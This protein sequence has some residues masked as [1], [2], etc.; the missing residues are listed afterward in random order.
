[1]LSKVQLSLKTYILIFVLITVY[2]LPT[3]LSSQAFL[4][5]AS[6]VNLAPLDPSIT[7]LELF[8]L[9]GKIHKR[10]E[11]KRPAFS[12]VVKTILL[13]LEVVC[14]KFWMEHCSL[15]MFEVRRLDFKLILKKKNYNN[16]NFSKQRTVK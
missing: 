10:W 4:I 7:H 14:I 6:I 1:M 8:I 15:W 11:V 13:I 3:I 9:S 5:Y 12:L 2:N 16:L